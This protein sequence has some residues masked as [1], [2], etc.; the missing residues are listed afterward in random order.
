MC[1]LIA[2]IPKL[3]EPAE[4]ASAEGSL[5]GHPETP[6][7]RA[8]RTRPLPSEAL[9]ST[10]ARARRRSSAPGSAHART[11]PNSPAISLANLPESGRISAPL[12]WRRR[13]EIKVQ[14][15]HRPKCF[16]VL[17]RLGKARVEGDT[18]TV[19]AISLVAMTTRARLAE[20]M[21]RI[22]G[23]IASSAPP[24]RHRLRG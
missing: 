2:N 16:G 1:A 15:Q 13:A 12:V 8:P 9:P 22:P 11:P 7:R 10:L 19:R 3:Q 17:L 18:G 21:S 14:E 24:G 6:T 4:P 5:L 23:F 20:K